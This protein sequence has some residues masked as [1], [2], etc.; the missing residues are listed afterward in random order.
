MR[1]SAWPLAMHAVFLFYMVEG[2]VPFSELVDE[3]L[4]DE[5]TVPLLLIAIVCVRV[6]AR[7]CVYVCTTCA[8]ALTYARRGG[9]SRGGAKRLVGSS[10]GP[11]GGSTASAA[12]AASDGNSR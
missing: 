9:G 6:R 11:D 3:R 5:L 2:S 1:A 8:R 7:A 12:E 4:W 10:W